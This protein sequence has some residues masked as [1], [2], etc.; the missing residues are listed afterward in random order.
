MIGQLVSKYQIV[1]ILGRGAMGIV[2][3]AIDTTGGP[4]VAR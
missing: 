2:F 1:E 4:A 3:R